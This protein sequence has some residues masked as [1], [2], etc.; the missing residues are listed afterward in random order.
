MENF[1]TFYPIHIFSEHSPEFVVPKYFRFNETFDPALTDFYHKQA[2][3]RK[4]N[5]VVFDTKI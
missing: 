3:R 4:K 5:K 2:D 1:Q